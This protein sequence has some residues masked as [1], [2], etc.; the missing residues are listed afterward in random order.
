V[1]SVP[2][3]GPAA[4]PIVPKVL[5]YVSAGPS[6]SVGVPN[7][8]LL[9]QYIPESGLGPRSEETFGEVVDDLL[10]L[11][12]RACLSRVWEAPAQTVCAI[13]LLSP[14]PACTL[15]TFMPS[16]GGANQMS[17][18][19]WRFWLSAMFLG[20]SGGSAL[21]FRVSRTAPH[22]DNIMVTTGVVSPTLGVVWPPYPVY[23]TLISGSRGAMPYDEK[24]STLELTV[25][26]RNPNAWR[27]PSASFTAATAECL[28]VHCELGFVSD[29]RLSLWEAAAE[30]FIVGG[31]LR[32][33][34]LELRANN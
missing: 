26:D 33:P 20:N 4:T 31:F 23:A 14:P 18:W 10:L 22:G 12:R 13:P 29:S 25:P 30:D 32:A 5:L 24:H 8:Q 11:T 1:V 34:T 7:L 6:F 3:A 2:S 16:G 21:K 15:A 19:T 17:C 9:E 27:Y 28:I